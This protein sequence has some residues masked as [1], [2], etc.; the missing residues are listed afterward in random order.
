MRATPQASDAKNAYSWETPRRRGLAATAEMS[1][2]KKVDGAAAN[3]DHQG[4]P[5]KKGRGRVRTE[6]M[7]TRT[8]KPAAGGPSAGVVAW[9]AGQLRAAGVGPEIAERL[10]ADRS[11]DLHAVIELT[12]RGCPAELALRILAPLDD[13][14]CDA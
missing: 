3:R 2:G 5:G 8:H 1:M 14:I 7:S 4:G 12:E 11:Y 10:A 6:V 13:G 9:R